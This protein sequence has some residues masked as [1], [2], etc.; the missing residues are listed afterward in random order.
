M[1]TAMKILIFGFGFLG[2]PL[3]EKCADAG[4]DVRVVKRSLSSDDINLPIDLDVVALTPNTPM[5]AE[6][7]HYDT[8]VVLLPPSALGT[9]YADSICHLLQ[10][11]E[12]LGI[13]H[14]VYSSSISVLGEQTGILYED[15]KVQADTVSAQHIFAVEQAIQ[16]SSI[17]HTD[18]LRLGGLYSSER[19]PIT[20]L[21][22]QN[23]PRSDG[24]QFA[25]MLHRDRAVSALFHAIMQANGKRLRHC[26]ETPHIS[27]REFYQAEANK[28]GLPSPLWQEHHA[29][30]HAI[31]TGK[32]VLSHYTDVMI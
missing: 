13:Q 17:P 32:K 27:K 30:E 9:H 25:N 11:A 2:R 21:L 7:K 15:A 1:Q 23:T 16:K 31:N 5:R 28:L 3:A 6:W 12:Q 26:V 29:D 20:R 24:E 22:Q 14:W 8:W 4:C 19:H 18:I 10:H